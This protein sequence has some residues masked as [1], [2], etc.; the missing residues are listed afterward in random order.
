MTG[1]RDRGERGSVRGKLR[2]RQMAA[3]ART[4][5]GCFRVVGAYCHTYRRRLALLALLSPVASVPVVIHP[6]LMELLI[7]KAY[8][9][10]DFFLF[11][12]LFAALTGMS[13]L[14]RILT[15]VS[16]YHATYVQALIEYKLSFRAFAAIGRLP[17]SYREQCDS[18]VFLV[19]A[20]NDVQVVAKSVTQRVPEIATLVFT[21]LSVIPLMVKISP[22]IALIILAIVPVN[23][24][25]TAHLTGKTIRLHM[26]EYA[27]AERMATFTQETVEGVTLSRIFSLDRIRRKQLANL[28]RERLNVMFGLWRANTTWGELAAAINMFWHTM[29]L[30]GGWYLVFS[31][32]LQLGQ[33]VALS[34]YI[35]ALR[36]PFDQLGSLYQWLLADSVAARRLLEILEAG[37]APV[38][39]I[40][41]K[42]LTV[43]PRRYE[44]HEL[45]FGYTEQRLCLQNLDLSLRAGQTIALIGPTGGGKST[46]IRILC[47]LEDRYQGQFLVDGQDFR[48]IDHDSYLQHVSLVPQTTFFFSGPIRSNLPGNGSVS[49]ARLHQCA[50]ALGLNTLIDSIPDGFG[51]ELGSEG[52]RL[53]GGQ[54]QK[55]AA[56]RAML[57]NAPVLLLDEVTASMDIE[58]ER[59]LLQG[60]IALRPPDCLT[61]LVTHH[62]AITTEPWI[63]DIVVLMDGRIAERGS[64]AELLEKRGFYHRWLRL[65]EGISS[66][67]T[68]LCRSASAA[69]R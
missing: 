30:G 57:K 26:A 10:R 63:D 65:S 19:R 22:G 23:Y 11:G 58:S 38:R 35:S 5:L 33:A 3:E 6:W 51:T 61:L 47:G 50:S 42:V 4:A 14:S 16:Q 46:L 69:E 44:L 27:V 7:D 49:V 53:S 25:I 21:F 24:L 31:N 39:L 67:N 55:L 34:M 17:Q 28:L 36:R 12:W 18:G 29:L 52:I 32:R 64:C 66:C 45:S 2:L 60:L 20:G 40:Q 48:D 56:L 1:H 43:P 9:S 37:Q 15:V 68:E 41:Q 8:P 54:Y 62:I 13:T 59:K